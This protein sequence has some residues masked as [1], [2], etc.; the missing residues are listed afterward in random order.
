MAAAQ[1]GGGACKGC[2]T[3]LGTIMNVGSTPQYRSTNNHNF[4]DP[5]GGVTA[6]ERARAYYTQFA[7]NITYLVGV[8]WAAAE[9]ERL[10]NEKCEEQGRLRASC[11]GAAVATSEERGKNEVDAERASRA[12]FEIAAGIYQTAPY[13]EQCYLLAHVFNLTE[14]KNRIDAKLGKR[15]PYLPLEERLFS[16]YKHTG[17]TPD[18]VLNYDGN[19]HV[20]LNGPPFGFLNLL[21]QDPKL[22]H[23]WGVSPAQLSALQPMIRLFKLQTNEDREGNEFDTEQELNFDSHLTS[24][25]IRLF[26]DRD[27]RGMGAGI[28]SFDFTYDGHNPF[29]AK[30]S[31]K[32]QLKIFA[33]SFEELLRDRGGYRYIDLALKTGNT[34]KS[35]TLRQ[36]ADEDCDQ[37]DATSTGADVP[38]GG[39]AN[40]DE[41]DKLRFRLK[42]VVGYASPNF[43]EGTN[44]FEHQNISPGTSDYYTKFTA[45]TRDV[46][47][48]ARGHKLIDAVDVS[49]VTLNLTPTIHNYDIDDMGRVT[50]TI[51]YLAYVEDFFDSP[52][53][54][55]FTN[56]EF[57][58][59]A[60]LRKLQFQRINSVCGEEDVD[61]FK[62]KEAEQIKKDKIGS[63]AT[64]MAT[65]Y[66]RNIVY[67]LNMSYEELKEF[68]RRGPYA[69]SN[70]GRLYSP[71]EQEQ[72][73]QRA[74]MTGA[75]RR[76]VNDT[77]EQNMGSQQTH[78]FL[79]KVANDMDQVSLP[80]FYVGDLLDVILEQIEDYL[81]KMPQTLGEWIE[82]PP[83]THQGKKFPTFITTCDIEFEKHKLEQFKKQFKQF[84]A[85]L[86]PVEIVP[87][88]GEPKSPKNVN[89]AQFPISVKY[90]MEWLTNQMLKKERTTYNLPNFLNDFFNLLIRNFLNDDTCFK[91]PI[92]QKVRC[93]QTVLSDYN[94]TGT[95]TLTQAYK[96]TRDHRLSQYAEQNINV[97]TT[98]LPEYIP[99]TISKETIPLRTRPLLN[100]SGPSPKKPVSVAPTQNYNY[101]VYFAGRTQPK[102]H[103][104]GDFIEDTDNGIFHFQSR[105]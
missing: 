41:L 89:F 21:T 47:T 31:I 55:I 23:L 90:F 53:F 26:K 88:T 12:A 105:G 83:T 20:A 44:I 78:L 14:K 76:G 15:I 87:Q 27:M 11:A 84:R 13:R 99:V 18:P 69:T 7:K 63:L 48:G 1:R 28:Q 67:F 102:E 33:S 51:N 54:N 72:I 96:W 74:T 97:S 95:D 98:N 24:N 22:R 77:D 32:A 30:K 60:L 39:A 75:V 4:T 35:T 103:M 49:Y 25:D 36:R 17:T 29:A 92:K 6:Y 101:L 58:E 73:D 9:N 5:G 52:T 68:E 70:A 10:Y 45:E 46:S 38:L 42:A 50:L 61:D 91:V 80:F 37:T 34:L 62:E 82:N 57:S 100:I 86:G 64:L 19:A 85:V 93:T 43:K 2:W 79:S 104:N 81:S 94:T 56:L 16:S 71:S 59:R 8:E 65:L 3:T 40:E 66:D